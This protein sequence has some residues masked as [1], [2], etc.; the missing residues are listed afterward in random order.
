MWATEAFPDPKVAYRGGG[1]VSFYSRLY[2]SV[3]C[4][5]TLIAYVGPASVRNESSVRS[6]QPDLSPAWQ[7]VH[8]TP[9]KRW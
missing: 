7:H 3:H 6:N 8:C 5:L 2:Y 4:T 1:V 9:C